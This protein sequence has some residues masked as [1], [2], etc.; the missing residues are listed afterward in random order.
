M[1]G[2]V[3]VGF[4]FSLVSLFLQCFY[5]ILE[6]LRHRGIFVFFILFQN[7]RPSLQLLQLGRVSDF[8]PTLNEHFSVISWREKATFNEMMMM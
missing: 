4:G 6:L 2:H 7:S 8:Y 1:N 5:W 3:Y